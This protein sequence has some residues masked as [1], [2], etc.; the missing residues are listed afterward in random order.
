MKSEMNIPEDFPYLKEE[1]LV[2]ADKRR[3]DYSRARD[4]LAKS[5]NEAIALRLA[6]EKEKKE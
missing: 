5:D 2:A 4:L 3:E 6:R 1:D